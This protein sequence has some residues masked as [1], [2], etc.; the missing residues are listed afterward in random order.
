V[1]G[2][3][4]VES[5]TDDGLWAYTV[6]GY[7]ASGNASTP[8]DGATARVY[9]PE[10]LAPESPTELTSVDL[11]GTGPLAGVTAVGEVENALGTTPLPA[12]TADGDGA[13]AFPG[14]ALERGLNTLTVRL[15]DGDG[16]LSKD[17]A[18]S[19]T[20]APAP[21]QP[22]G[23]GATVTGQQLDLT[24][25]ANAEADLLGYR[26]YRDGEGIPSAQT[27]ASY[28]GATASSAAPGGA[29][30]S[31]LDGDAGTLWRPAPP[32]GEGNTGEWVAIRWAQDL[33]LSAVEIE[34]GAATPAADFDLEVELEGRF[35]PAATVRG[36]TEAGLTVPLAEGSFGRALR[37]TLVSSEA[38]PGVAE[39]RTVFEPLLTGTAYAESLDDGSYGYTLRAVNTSGFAS[40]LSEIVE[41]S[42]GD[43]IPPGPGALSGVADGALAE[44][45][46]TASEAPDLERYDLL[47]GGEVIHSHTDLA[48]LAFTNGPLANGTYLYQVEGVDVGGNRSE[49]SNTVAVTIAEPLPAAPVL[50]SATPGVATLTVTWEPAAG[51]SPSAYRDRKS[52][53]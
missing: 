3:T 24:W 34:F 6:R 4:F 44:L 14:I 13:F 43:G 32:A 19:V 37:L 41:V 33:R 48:T 15:T 42:V 40:P 31:V 29:P 7:D 47:R 5:G 21:A 36:N 53:V 1:A 38:D 11:S 9:T 25:A 50:T 52:V 22:Q 30:V 23:L 39:L 26:L 45:S 46:W 17:A 8:S 16:N 2:P 28:S 12:V 18:V 10:L 27:L 20:S 49:A 35:R 51:S